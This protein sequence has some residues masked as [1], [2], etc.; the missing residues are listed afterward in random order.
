[1]RPWRI[2]RAVPA[3]A[4]AI[5]AIH[6]RAIRETASWHYEPDT[7]AAWSG[8]V[9][10]ASYAESIETLVL[11]VAEDDDA[12]L[13]GFAE[14]DPSAGIVRAC[15]VDPDYERQGV[16][17]ALMRA[18]EDEARA[19]GRSALLLDAS[20]NA[21][22]FYESLGWKVETR[23]RHDL[24]RGAGLDCAVMRKTIA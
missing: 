3:D 5:W 16:G 20:L 10:P 12:R 2:R 17:R 4:A 24:G 7:I 14:L 15:Y 11:V 21:I 18:V 19:R 13:A 9:T 8:R 23:A 6:T 1:M 22:A